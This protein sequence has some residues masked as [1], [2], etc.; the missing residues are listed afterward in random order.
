MV[1]M[2]YFKHLILLLGLF[3]SQ[4]ISAQDN[5]HGLAIVSDVERYQAQVQQ[6]P[7]VEF[8]DLSVY[9]PEIRL[10]IRYATDNNFTGDVIYEQAKAYVRIHVAKALNRINKQLAKEGLALKVYDAYRPYAATL[11]F[12]KVY[13][14]TNYVAAPWTGS[15]HN[16]GCAVDVTLIDKESGKE[17]EMPTKFDDFTDKAAPNARDVSPEAAKNRDK[18]IKVMNKYGFIVNANEWWHYDMKG[19]EEYDLMDISFSELAQIKNTK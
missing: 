9:A 2:M 12:Y 3:V 6:N 10:D 14:D 8:V 13:P 5:P 15:V 1:R 7:S 11:K 18:L 16:R 4:F 19:W 17:L